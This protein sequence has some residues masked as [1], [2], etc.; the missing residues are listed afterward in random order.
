VCIAALH[1]HDDSGILHI[2]SQQP[3][4]YTLGEI[5]TEWNVRLDGKCVGGYCRPAAGIAVYVK[6]KRSS[7]DPANLVLQDLE[8][9]AIVIGSPPATIPSSY[10]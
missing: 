1:T 7:G 3:R 10:F 2:E 5:F 8:E 6:G 9:I 4:D